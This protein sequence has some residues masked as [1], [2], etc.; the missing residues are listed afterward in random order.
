MKR[1]QSLW[2][3]LGPKRK[4]TCMNV[5]TIQ[6]DEFQAQVG[7]EWV[8]TDATLSV[9]KYQSHWD[10]G[11]TSFGYLSFGFGLIDFSPI[12][13]V[14]LFGPRLKYP[15]L[16]ITYSNTICTFSLHSTRHICKNDSIIRKIAL[17]AF[18]RTFPFKISLLQMLRPYWIYYPLKKI[19]STAPIQT[20]SEDFC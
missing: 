7:L 6:T 2:E 17:D 12:I 18:F 19:E 16:E 10:V 15:P 14:W 9:T 13:S 8:A 3:G 20:K 1:P 4:D 11:T 5:V